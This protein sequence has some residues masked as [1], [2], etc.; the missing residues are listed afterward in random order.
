MESKNLLF[1]SLVSP[2]KCEVDMKPYAGID[3]EE[4][5]EDGKKERENTTVVSVL[6][7]D[8]TKIRH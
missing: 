2:L 8:A 3:L 6:Q 7:S 5:R 4:F 1:T